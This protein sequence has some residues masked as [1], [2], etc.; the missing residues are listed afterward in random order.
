MIAP[1]NAGTTPSHAAR[2]MP[3][4]LELAQAA[5]ART[6]SDTE[7]RQSPTVGPIG[8]LGAH[9][10]ATW[11]TRQPRK[12][13][14]GELEVLRDVA[15][16]LARVDDVLDRERLR[17]AERTRDSTEA[18]FELRPPRLGIGGVRNVA[19]ARPGLYLSNS[20]NL[21]HFCRSAIFM[22]FA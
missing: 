9:A 18:G 6:R 21:W 2:E 19:P 5:L 16:R 11:F 8:P 14:V 15:T 3:F 4:D 12:R 7:D 10:E 22:G 17:R 1:A 13:A 20:L